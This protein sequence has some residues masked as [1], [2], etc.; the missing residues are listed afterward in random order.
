MLEVFR[1]HGERTDRQKTRMLWLIEAKGLDWFRE[2]VNEAGAKRGL[3]PLPRAAPPFEGAFE[4]RDIMG[5][6]PQKQEGKSWVGVTVPAGRVTPAEMKEVADLADEFSG[7]EI[8]FT[9]EQ[10]LLLPNVDNAR[11]PELLAAPLFNRGGMRVESGVSVMRGLVAC[12]GSNGCG[13]GLV[14]TKAR[15]IRVAERLDAE[16]EL[17][18]LVRV[19]W[20]GCPNS[21]GQAQV[22]DIGLMG[23]PAKKM[24][25]ETGKAMA[26]E[27]SAPRRGG[28]ARAARARV[29]ATRACTRGGRSAAWLSTRHHAPARVPPRRASAGRQG[30]P[31]WEGG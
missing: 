28:G 22:G 29:G 10:N 14:E 4:R 17:P 16:L 1:D 12:T 23:S 6:H 15:A 31:G 27:V 8:R 25:P 2:K 7:G 18:R 19:H 11:V 24:N 5:V 30:V 3:D 26:V 20:T 9:V 13:Q 21:C